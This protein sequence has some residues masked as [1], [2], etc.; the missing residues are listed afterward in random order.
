MLSLESFCVRSCLILLSNKTFSLSG[1]TVATC[2]F[3]CVCVCVCVEGSGWDLILTSKMCCSPG[4]LC[5]VTVK[6]SAKQPGAD[7]TVDKNS[8][9]RLH[10]VL[11]RLGVGIRNGQCGS[12]VSIQ[13]FGQGG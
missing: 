13:E 9:L 4:Y 8:P 11:V 7:A 6:G 3:V 10:V 2:V 1:L 12:F 5:S